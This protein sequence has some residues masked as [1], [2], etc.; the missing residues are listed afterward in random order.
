MSDKEAWNFYVIGAGDGGRGAFYET[1]CLYPIRTLLFG[2]STNHQLIQGLF[3]T[4]GTFV[5]GPEHN[6]QVTD[7]HGYPLS[8]PRYLGGQ[9]FSECLFYQPVAS[10]S[11]ESISL[12]DATQMD[13]YYVNLFTRS[14]VHQIRK[15]DTQEIEVSAHAHSGIYDAVIVTRRRGPSR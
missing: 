13:R 7:S 8:S 12:Y 4:S 6:Q 10:A 3:D 2:F 5:P 1:S 9:T 15:L 14:G 11:V